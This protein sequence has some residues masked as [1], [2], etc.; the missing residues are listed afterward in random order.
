MFTILFTFLTSL[1]TDHN[2]SAIMAFF[3]VGLVI[4]IVLICIYT[5][6]AKCIE[7][8]A[9][10]KGYPKSRTYYYAT[11][12]T[13]ITGLI[14]ALRLPNL[15]VAPAAP[16]AEEAPIAEEVPVAEE[17]PAEEPAEV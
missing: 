11:R 16:A 14:Y 17:A 7:K 6:V 8:L 1:I 2:D 3:L 5:W 15:T 12:F 13:W 10:R 9:I 4:D